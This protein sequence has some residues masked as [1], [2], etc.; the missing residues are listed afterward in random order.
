V[1]GQYCDTEVCFEFL[2]ALSTKMAVLWVVAS[3][4]LIDISL[5]MFQRSDE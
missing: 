3:C 4:G 5:P 1:R 2:A